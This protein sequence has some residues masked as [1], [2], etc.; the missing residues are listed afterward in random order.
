MN[1]KRTAARTASMKADRRRGL[2]I[3]EI[4]AKN[5]TSAS[6]AHAAVTSKGPRTAKP[7]AVVAPSAAPPT[8]D[9]PEPLPAP[10]REELAAFLGAQV[11]SLMAE[12]AAST[13]APIRAAANRSLV[14]CQALLT[15][16][17]PAA[18][19][20]EPEGFYVSSGDM[21]EA[22]ARC[23]ARLHQRLDAIVREAKL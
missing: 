21:H 13:D 7:A 8:G 2:T 10:T 23:R 3:A 15:K 16:V 22:A 4:A 5:G 1:K 18:E 12:V 19:P 14:A 20:A 11:R 9:A 17:L 6:T